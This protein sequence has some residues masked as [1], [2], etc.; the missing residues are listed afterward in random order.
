MQLLEPRLAPAGLPSR[1]ATV[2]LADLPAYRG[3]FVTNARGI[4]PVAR[5][6]DVELAV[7]GELM[8]AV[9]AVYASVPWDTIADR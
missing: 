8:Q 7:D 6:D 2:R 3:A 5:I 4:A 1:R 9:A